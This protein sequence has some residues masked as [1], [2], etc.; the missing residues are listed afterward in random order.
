VK[1]P[2]LDIAA[3]HAPIRAELDAAYQRVADSNW[4]ITGRELSAFEEEFARYCGVRHCIGVANGLD[5]LFLIL[6][7]WDIGPGDEVLVPSNTFIASWLAVT[8]SGAT[9]IPVEPLAQTYNLDPERLRAAI[10]PR[11]RA[12]MPVHLYGQPADMSPIIEIAREFGLKVVEDAAQ[13]HGARYDGKVTGGLGD[14]AGFSFY[15]GKNL[16]ALGDGGAITT[17]DDAL[18]ERVRLLR[19]YGSR[20]KYRHEIAG[21]NSRLDELQAAFLREKLRKL[22]E[23]NDRRRRIAARYSAALNDSPLTIPFVPTWA[24][25]SWHLYVIRHPARDLL[26]AR[27]AESGVETLIHY[28]MPPH[29]QAAYAS[30]DVGASLPISEQLHREVLSLPMSPQLSDEAVEMV[31]GACLDCSSGLSGQ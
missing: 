28:P 25:P 15:P 21:F 27:L 14:A 30:G 2:F 1:V 20:V 13:G 23:W 4:F 6:K 26:Q 7:G 11:T 19:N 5:A 22:D 12:I 31:I 16:G 9:P 17:D 18:A 8:H 3:M 29:R 10:T 24:D